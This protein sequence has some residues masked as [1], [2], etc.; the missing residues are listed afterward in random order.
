MDRCCDHKAG[1]L[2]Q[3]RARQGRVLY[4][5]LAINAVMFFVEFTAGW[6]VHSTALL[7]DSLDMLGDA[8]V[9]VIS[10]YVLHRGVRA[11]AGAALFKSGFLMLLSFLIIGEAIRKSIV[12]VV[13]EAGWMALIGFIALAANLTCL[14]LLYRHRGDD[15]NMSSTWLCSRNDVIAN[16]SVL[17]AAG[18]VL[19][20]ESLWP[21]MVVGVALAL[22]YL[23]SSRQVARDA[24]PQWRV[25]RTPEGYREVS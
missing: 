22:L 25:R 24:W 9:Y 14:G 2:A 3:L 6:L 21:D 7:G 23:H 10:L 12:G 5:V 16:L 19:L 17:A 20:T 1:E 8:L 11:R 18:L 13:P 15:V 4:I